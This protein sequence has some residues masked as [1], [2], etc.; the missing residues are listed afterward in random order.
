MKKLEKAD[1]EAEQRDVELSDETVAALY[2]K[3]GDG[4]PPDSDPGTE[5]ETDDDAFESADV[6]FENTDVENFL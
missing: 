2:A 1:E 4:E 3:Y 5:T 6:E